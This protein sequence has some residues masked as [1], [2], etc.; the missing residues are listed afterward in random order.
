MHKAKT[1]FVCGG[2]EYYGG[3][4]GNYFVLPLFYLVLEILLLLENYFISLGFFFD[5]HMKG[6]FPS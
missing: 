4:A 3:G 1:P 2:I 5:I 6:K